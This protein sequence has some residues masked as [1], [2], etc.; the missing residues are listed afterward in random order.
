M[1][2]RKAPAQQNTLHGFFTVAQSSTNQHSSSENSSHAMQYIRG[3]TLRECSAANHV[4]S[5]N[6]LSSKP[7][8]K[9]IPKYLSV[10][11]KKHSKI[12]YCIGWLTGV[13]HS[14]VDIFRHGETDDEVRVFLEREP[15]NEI[16]KSSSEIDFCILS[17]F[18]YFR[19]SCQGWKW[20]SDRLCRDA[21]EQ[22]P[23]STGTCTQ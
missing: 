2:R 9:S 3:E 1:K 16:G 8:N 4:S 14:N 21:N 23:I 20:G 19:N 22:I 15:T 6:F 5:I 11:Q 12:E 10:M 7:E 18:R 13:R 17:V